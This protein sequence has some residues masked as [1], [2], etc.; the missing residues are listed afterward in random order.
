[1]NRSLFKDSEDDPNAI[2]L[3]L[4]ATDPRLRSSLPQGYDESLNSISPAR[5]AGRLR[6]SHTPP[7]KSPLPRRKGPNSGTDSTLSSAPPA[8]SSTD[9]QD[10]FE[11]YTLDPSISPG[12]YRGGS[13]GPAY[14]HSVEAEGDPYRGDPSISPGD[15]RGGSEYRD[16]VEAEGDPY[17]GDP[18]ISPGDYRGGSEGP[19]YRVSVEAEGD[20]YRGDP[21]ISPGG[22]PY[23]LPDSPLQGQSPVPGHTPRRSTVSL[24]RSVDATLLASGISPPSSTLRRS[25]YPDLLTGGDEGLERDDTSPLAWSLPSHAGD[26]YLLSPPSTSPRAAASLTSPSSPRVHTPLALS[27]RFQPSTTVVHS[28]SHTPRGTTHPTP[29]TLSRMLRTIK[30]PIDMVI[31]ACSG[32]AQEDDGVAVG[33]VSTQLSARIQQ[34]GTPGIEAPGTPCADED[35]VAALLKSITALVSHYTQVHLYLNH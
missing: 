20:P 6:L 8:D 4:S 13:E 15:Y 31:R 21:S 24:R 3:S 14:R 26:S 12:D 5:D 27:P 28:G 1:M 18:S 11:G 23:F 19:A 9:H 25:L 7:R 29:R 22:D 33:A 17:R 16:S 32:D 30:A 10:D 2:D 34:A 35:E